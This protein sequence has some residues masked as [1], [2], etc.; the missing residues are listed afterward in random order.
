MAFLCISII[1]IGLN[2][3][4]KNM[5][6]VESGRP[7]R[8]E[9]NR[10]ALQIEKNGFQ[11]V[12][13]SKCEYVNYIEAFQEDFYNSDSD[14]VICEINGTLYRFDY[15]AKNDTGN[16]KMVI[17]VNGILAVM[18]ALVFLILLYIQKEILSPFER[19]KDV[20]YELSKGNLTFPVRENK[21]RFFGKFLWGID[22]LRESM[23]QQ[24][25]RELELEREKKTL[26][27]SL[28]HDIKTPLS[29]IKLY[30]KALSR[31]LYSDR[32]KQRETAEKINEKADEI[33]HYVSRI[34]TASRE[35]FLS[36]E[37]EDGEFYLGELV[38]NIA[39][40]YSEKLALVKTEFIIGEYQ[41]CL[42]FGD[43]D[44]SVEVLQNLMENA[45]KYGDGKRITLGFSNDDEGVFVSVENSGCTLAES[46]LP[47]IFESFW[48]GRNSEKMEGSGLGLYICR[49]LMHKMNGDIFA[50]MNDGVIEITT[51]F[52]RV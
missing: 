52:R 40:Y 27:L 32:E 39:A 12:D 51:I 24:K 28:S 15:D 46:D 49:Q 36:L 35:D 44:R 2:L 17:M 6:A 34:I 16:K 48:R 3:L 22:M 18:S 20:P 41:D 4:L 38:Q 31:N 9:I 7:Y 1:F 5:S 47:H 30:A 13:L 25:R 21:N 37:A 8:V 43:F 26:L 33:E 29:A 10:I 19:L 42:I 23:E 14:Y 50:E 45:I 11:S